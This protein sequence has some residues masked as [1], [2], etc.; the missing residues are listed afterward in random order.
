MNKKG[1]VKTGVRRKL[2]ERKRVIK[3]LK[4]VIICKYYV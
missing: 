3:K 2:I 4:S 1:R